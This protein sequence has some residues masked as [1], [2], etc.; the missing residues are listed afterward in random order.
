M[1]SESGVKNRNLSDAKNKS[2][3]AKSKMPL[4]FCAIVVASILVGFVAGMLL[5]PKHDEAEPEKQK[6]PEAAKEEDHDDETTSSEWGDAYAKYFTERNELTDTNSPVLSAIDFMNDGTPEILL[7]YTTSVSAKTQILY[8][9]AEQKVIASDSYNNARLVLLYPIEET[10]GEEAQP[11]L[12]PEPTWYLYNGSD[13]EYGR[14]VKV[15]DIISGSSNPVFIN[16]TTDASLLS[17]HENYVEISPELDTYQLNMKKIYPSIKELVQSGE[18]NPINDNIEKSVSGEISDRYAVKQ[19]EA[20][21]KKAAEEKAKAESEA[22]RISAG[23]KV[24]DYTVAYGGYSAKLDGGATVKIILKS[25]GTFT[26]EDTSEGN[27]KSGTFVVENS[28]IIL[29]TKADGAKLNVTGN[30]SLK[31]N[32]AVLTK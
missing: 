7:N 21:D 6:E 14:Y 15:S 11:N 9:D 23:I 29:G 27:V 18:Y 22:E 24:G 13:T 1:K 5:F 4:I 2:R 12:K 26:M 10:E 17:L 20:E 25:D 28:T 32:D 8:L 31:Y 30:N 19:K 3:K 16:A